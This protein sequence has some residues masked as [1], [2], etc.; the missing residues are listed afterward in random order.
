MDIQGKA[1][2]GTN[3]KKSF[4]PVISSTCRVLI[5]GSLPG[6]E[7]LRQSQYYAFPRNCFWKIM[8]ELFGFDCDRPYEKRLDC[9]LKGG[10]ALWDV[11]Q[12]GVR[13]G[14]LD[15]HISAV[16]S[17]DIPALLRKYSG[18]RRICCNG[19]ASYRFLK[20]SFPSLWKKPISILQLPSTSPAAA[21]FSYAE[22]RDVWCKAIREVME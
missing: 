17:N 8:S 4:P 2:Y 3:R 22:K 5:L 20:R 11:V 10:V 15:Q 14:S 1:S 12:S 16:V 6:E 18:I 21:R 19:G 7:S 9:L 13:K